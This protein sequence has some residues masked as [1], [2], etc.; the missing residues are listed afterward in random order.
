MSKNRGHILRRN[1]QE[2]WLSVVLAF[3]TII[4]F[5]IFTYRFIDRPT[6]N[7]RSNIDNPTLFTTGYL[8][9]SLDATEKIMK[10]KKLNFDEARLFIGGYNKYIASRKKE[11]IQIGHAQHLLKKY[12]K[13]M[14]P[15][16]ALTIIIYAEKCA[17]DLIQ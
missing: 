7:V 9:I 4:A 15:K 3:L 2:A 16:R 10:S 17:E 1:R 11:N 5:C 8:E 14:S 13:R 6:E 12:S